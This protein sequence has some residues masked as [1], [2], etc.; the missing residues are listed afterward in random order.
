M[1]GQGESMLAFPNATGP[2]FRL[3]EDHLREGFA[4]SRQSSRRRVILPLHRT[5]DARVQRMLNFFQPG[6]YVHPHVHPEEGQSELVHVLRGRLG[7]LLFAP[8]GELTGTH[9]LGEG[10]LIDL[11]PG[12]WHGMI[13]L[14]PDTA[15][16]EIKRG[17]YCAATD[18]VF[19]AWAPAES[20]PE[21]EA[22]VAQW[23]SLFKDPPDFPL[24]EAGIR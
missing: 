17:P 8:T 4:A 1:V 18:K 9:D 23:G 2:V 7:F 19:A 5:Q 6:T 15:I 13:C 12:Q 24:S 10:E 3:K 11:E 21:A 14:A 16:V 22:R 20:A